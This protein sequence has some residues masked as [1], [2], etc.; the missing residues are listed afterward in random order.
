MT[1]TPGIIAILVTIASFS[2]LGAMITYAVLT[3][4]W[5]SRTGI[6]FMSMQLSFVA[7]L[8]IRWMSIAGIDVPVSL[9]ASSWVFV[10][11]AVNVGITYN[12]IYQQFIK[13]HP[14]DMKK[15]TDRVSRAERYERK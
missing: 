10:I 15:S 13:G 4:W 12:I 7:V 1:E 11:L 6:G 14:D 5:R 9:W 3:P 2:I 8:A